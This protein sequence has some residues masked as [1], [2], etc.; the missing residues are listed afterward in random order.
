MGITVCRCCGG[1]VGKEEAARNSHVC[2]SCEWLSDEVLPER[3][4]EPVGLAEGTAEANSDPTPQR[5]AAPR[6]G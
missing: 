6:E 1:P 4:A 5:M 3:E 2:K